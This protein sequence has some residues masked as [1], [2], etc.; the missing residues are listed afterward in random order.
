MT[1]LLL[2][3]LLMLASLQ[4]HIG[5]AWQ[6]EIKEHRYC[7]GSCPM[8]G[9][10]EF[11]AWNDSYSVHVFIEAGERISPTL[12]VVCS[13]SASSNA[14]IN[15]EQLKSLKMKLR[16]GLTVPH[17]VQ[18]YGL[19]FLNLPEYNDSVHQDDSTTRPHYFA[20]WNWT[21]VQWIDPNSS[22]NLDRFQVTYRGY[23]ALYTPFSTGG[24]VELRFTVPID[25]HFRSSNNL[26]SIVVQC[27]VSLVGLHSSHQ[28]S[29]FGLQL[30]LVSNESVVPDDD[31]VTY[32][33]GLGDADLVTVRLDHRISSHQSFPPGA[34]LQMKG[35]D[36]MSLE[37]HSS[38]ARVFHPMYLER[39][40]H[41]PESKRRRQLI[42]QCLAGT[43]FGKR[44]YQQY[45]G[46]SSMDSV[47][48]QWVS[49][50][51][52]LPPVGIR[53]QSVHFPHSVDHSNAQPS[54]VVCS[55]DKLLDL[56]SR[57]ISAPTPP[58]HTQQQQQRHNK[59]GSPYLPY[60]AFGSWGNFK[61]VGVKFLGNV[62]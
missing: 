1:C 33:E 28:N 5:A 38:A 13:S 31:Y 7:G 12:L 57:S 26:S 9:L 62:G 47:A 16:Q 4:V 52:A 14:T 2:L 15:L 44:I 30:V 43:F 11:K 48:E 27:E 24:H 10:T 8:H 29:N 6:F 41:A 51:P 34:Y 3:P 19:V 20:N 36:H 37:Q 22:D 45:V 35:M 61:G 39:V 18:S 60:Y 21:L 54:T 40:K 32:R 58:K 53:L 55:A 17:A 59:C 49:G 25:A 50:T 56:P 23:G 46:L 42:S